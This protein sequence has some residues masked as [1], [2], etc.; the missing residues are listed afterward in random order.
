LT[1]RRKCAIFYI[2]EWPKNGKHPEGVLSYTYDPWGKLLSMTDASNTSIG[3]MNP[4]RYR[5]YYYDTE[6][7]WYYLNSRYYDPQGGIKYIWP[8]WILIP[9]GEY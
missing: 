7:G 3:T 9:F 8:T 4:F 6:T 5:G 1:K 2:G